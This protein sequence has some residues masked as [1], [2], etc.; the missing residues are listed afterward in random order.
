MATAIWWVPLVAALI[1][2]ISALGTTFL[3]EFVIERLNEGHVKT[4]EQRA[5][6]RNY[7]APL[8]AASEKLL[9]R[10]SEIFLEKRSQFLKTAT[11]PVAYNEYKR[12]L[13]FIGSHQ[14]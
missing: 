6:F 5:I 3:K 8:A 14:F 13:R 2:A 7:A 10:F 11:L 12:S 1:G 9:W 4:N